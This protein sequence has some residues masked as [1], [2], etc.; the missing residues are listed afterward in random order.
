MK[1]DFA[2][3][4]EFVKPQL[5]ITLF[6]AEDIIRTSPDDDRLPIISGE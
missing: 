3:K 1:G 4:E 5:E 6:E 2:L